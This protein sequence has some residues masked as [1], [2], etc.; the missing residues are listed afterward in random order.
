MS[1]SV[2]L[3]MVGTN[4]DLRFEADPNGEYGTTPG[5]TLESLGLIPYFVWE[6]IEDTT[7]DDVCATMA[8][9]YGYMIDD[10]N[11]LDYGGTIEE[12]YTYTS[13]EDEEGY[14]DPDLVPTAKFTLPSGVEVVTYPFSLVLVTNGTYHRM[15][16]MD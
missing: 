11:F 10:W 3:F 12:D 7:V 13:Q 2:M 16:R 1:E 5:K 14:K 4:K 8:E 9:C 6:A 15:T